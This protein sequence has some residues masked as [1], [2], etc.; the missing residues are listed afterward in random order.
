[1][2]EL[3]LLAQRKY[4]DPD[5]DTEPLKSPQE[6]A[7]QIVRAKFFYGPNAKKPSDTDKQEKP[8]KIPKLIAYPD[9]G[10]QSSV[11]NGLP[12]WF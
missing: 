5:T 8:S 4:K 7:F 9:T 12:L 2:T 11:D 1:M 6:C 10:F 3:P